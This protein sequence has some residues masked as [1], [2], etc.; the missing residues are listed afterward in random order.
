MQIQIDNSSNYPVYQQVIDQIKRDIAL[1][2]LR[3]NDQLLTVRQLAAELVINPNT[4]AKAYR[5][6]EQ[7]GV[8]TTKKGSGTFIAQLDSQ[9]S[10]SVRKKIIDQQIERLV[11]DAIHM[12]VDREKLSQWFSQSLDQFNWEQA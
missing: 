5:Q 8:I 2:R 10:Q 1:G 3:K 12:Q 9:L 7:E 6:L 4:I 11:V